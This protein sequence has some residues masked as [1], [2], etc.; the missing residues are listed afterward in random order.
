MDMII[1][2]KNTIMYWQARLGLGQFIMGNGAIDRYAQHG[3]LSTPFIVWIVRER[4]ANNCTLT[5]LVRLHR[6]GSSLCCLKHGYIRAVGLWNFI[7][8]A[9]RT[10]TLKHHHSPR[11]GWWRAFHH[12]PS[13]ALD[14]YQITTFKEW[15]SGKLLT[16]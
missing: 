4:L 11:P 7:V 15:F 14:N 13:Y 10:I 8:Q 2:A 9:W 3:M 12:S 6:L 5:N 16:Y 1:L